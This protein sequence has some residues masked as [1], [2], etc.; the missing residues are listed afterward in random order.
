MIDVVLLTEPHRVTR[1]TCDLPGCGAQ[2][3][4]AAG[5]DLTTS[6]WVALT[7]APL[8]SAAGSLVFDSYSHAAQLVATLP[9]P[10][11]NHFGQ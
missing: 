4:A 10:V 6:G 9:V 1:Y 11:P 7:I 8:G 3:I 2:I 5:V